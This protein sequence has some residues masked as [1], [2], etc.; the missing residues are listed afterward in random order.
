MKAAG[1]VVELV[2]DPEDEVT[3]AGCVVELVPDAKS[4]VLSTSCGTTHKI[5]PPAVI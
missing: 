1:C 4:V 3:A 2:P 5:F